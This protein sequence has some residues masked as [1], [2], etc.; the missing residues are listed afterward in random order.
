MAES[1]QLQ[2]GF[3]AREA[4][5]SDDADMA[6]DD[7]AAGLPR[8]GAVGAGGGGGQDEGILAVDIWRGEGG[9][10]AGDDEQQQQQN[11]LDD[12]SRPAALAGT[13]A[14]LPAGIMRARMRAIKRSTAPTQIQVVGGDDWTEV[15]QQSVRTPRRVNRGELRAL[16]ETGAAWER[17]EKEGEEETA[18]AAA[19]ASTMMK[20]STAAA[21]AASDGAG[22]ATGLD[23]MKSL[24]G[25]AP[26]EAAQPSPAKGFLKVG[27]VPLVF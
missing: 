15:L 27:A 16:N 26:S 21:A 12:L 22:F 14:L 18:A 1:D 11:D 3:R 5:P 7:L 8:E 13:D 4:T 9:E 25:G 10:D 2:Q 6:D 19:A 17:E 20:Q 23:L 24:F